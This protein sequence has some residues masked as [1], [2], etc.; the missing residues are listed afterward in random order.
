MSK[1]LKKSLAAIL[2]IFMMITAAPLEGF[3]G[4]EIPDPFSTKAEAADTVT[5]PNYCNYAAAEW[6]KQ[7]LYILF[8]PVQDAAMK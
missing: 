6:A 5:M 3:V 8:K 2:V 1:K 7:H 4:L